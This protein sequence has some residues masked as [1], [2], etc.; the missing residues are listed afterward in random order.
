MSYELYSRLY[1]RYIIAKEQKRLNDYV[2]I[3]PMT[4]DKFKDLR[5]SWASLLKRNNLP[6]NKITRY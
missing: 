3:N 6:K 2:F 1:K 4:D 5:K